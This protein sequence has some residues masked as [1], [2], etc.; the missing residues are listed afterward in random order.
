MADG[1]AS[2]PLLK[3]VW[4]GD[5]AS[6]L[7]CAALVCTDCGNTLFFNLIALGFALD[8]GP[9]LTEMRKKWGLT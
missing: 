3:N 7:P 4:T 1:F 2:V 5:R 8:I 6:S 9:D